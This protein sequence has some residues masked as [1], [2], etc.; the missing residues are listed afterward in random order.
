MY[1]TADRYEI[2]AQED[3][4]APRIKLHIP[5]HL[6]ISGQSRFPSVV[7]DLSL[8]GFCATAV[9][10][11]HPGTLCWLSLPGLE[12]MMA[13]VVWW[14]RSLVGCAFSQ[15]LG[16]IIYDNLLERWQGQEF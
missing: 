2:A 9:G 7:S 5:A 3:R 10:R 13:E 6:R 8:G 14:D 1:R 15:L 16:P 11:I 4:C 12:A